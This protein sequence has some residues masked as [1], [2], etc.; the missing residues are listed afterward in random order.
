LGFR[1]K[2]APAQP[3]TFFF[4]FLPFFGLA[5]TMSGP[6]VSAQCPLLATGAIFVNKSS[7]PALCGRALPGDVLPLDCSRAKNDQRFLVGLGSGSSVL[8][9]SARLRSVGI[10]FRRFGEQAALAKSC[11][12]SRIAPA[13]LGLESDISRVG[14]CDNGDGLSRPLGEF[15]DTI[16]EMLPD[17]E[18]PGRAVIVLDVSLDTRDNGRGMNSSVSEKPTRALVFLGLLSGEDLAAAGSAVSFGASA[19]GTGSGS[20][21]I[22]SASCKDPWLGCT[23]LVGLFGALFPRLAESKTGGWRIGRSLVEMA[24]EIPRRCPLLGGG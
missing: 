17:K 10:E 2:I 15:P 11:V 18:C 5:V 8:G 13:V 14:V 19:V 7:E 4:F 9:A 1:G 24:P 12:F 16:D 23:K 3:L 21:T 6:S 20:G 22:C